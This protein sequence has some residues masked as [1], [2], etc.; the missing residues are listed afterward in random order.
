[1]PFCLLASPPSAVTLN[2]TASNSW[3]CPYSPGIYNDTRLT[4]DDVNHD[5]E[6]VGWGEEDGVKVRATLQ[7]APAS[8]LALSLSSR[9]AL[10]PPSLAVPFA[11]LDRPEQLGKLL[12]GGWV[13]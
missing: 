13:L 2:L 5:V 6:V 8:T 10:M 4:G 3:A 9:A 7:P 12:G 11:V 1:M